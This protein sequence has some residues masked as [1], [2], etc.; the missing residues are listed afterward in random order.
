MLDTDQD[1]STIRDR[2]TDRQTDRDRETLRWVDG[3]SAGVIDLTC[4]ICCTQSLGK[5]RKKPCSVS[6]I[7]THPAPPPLPPKLKIAF[8]GCQYS[9]PSTPTFP[10]A[11]NPQPPPYLSVHPH[12]HLVP[13]LSPFPTPPPPFFFLPLL[14]LTL[15]PT[16]PPPPPPPKL[17]RTSRRYVSGDD[18]T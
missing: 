18:K 11:V 16:T 14:F 17:S 10:A 6:K 4:A 1:L 12:A 8:S 5:E 15:P 2:Q 9:F 3:L 13:A 7:P